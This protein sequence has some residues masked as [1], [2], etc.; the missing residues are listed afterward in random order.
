[1]TYSLIL[2]HSRVMQALVAD[3]L[4]PLIA[5]IAVTRILRDPRWFCAAHA[6]PSDTSRLFAATRHEAG[7]GASQQQ[8]K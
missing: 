1:M 5:S 4:D 3:T 7:R 2:L 6:R 8:Q